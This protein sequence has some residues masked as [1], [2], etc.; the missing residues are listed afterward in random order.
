[1][2]TLEFHKYS[3]TG[4]DFIVLDNREG[5]FSYDKTLW[6]KLCQRRTG[7]GADGVLFLE[8]ST[9]ADFKMVYLNADGNEVA[10][11]GNGSR[12][13]IH[14]ASELEVTQKNKG[15]YSF[16]TFN[17][18]Y[19]GRSTSAESVEVEMTELY[20]QGKIDI[21]DLFS[22]KNCLYL[23]TGVPHCIYE[24]DDVDQL[25]LKKLG[26]KIRY[27]KRFDEGTNVNFFQKLSSNTLKL[28]TYERGVED[29]TL[30]CGSGALAAAVAFSQF[31]GK[32]EK[33]EIKQ[34]GGTLIIGLTPKY[35]LRGKVQK[36]Y[37]G[38]CELM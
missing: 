4:N 28:R 20:D 9:K 12:A 22:A 1:M 19:F 10:M 32:V 29:E 8:N 31:Y 6:Q 11:C 30:A 34:P 33:V 13:L 15:L 36:I 27:D 17:G 7:I 5:L 23:N 26:E 2:S 18:V 16:E 35:T 3:A 14:F 25:E 38:S 24:V 21:S 37:S